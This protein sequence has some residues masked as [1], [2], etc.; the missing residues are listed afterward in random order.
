MRRIL[1]TLYYAVQQV[2]P[3]INLPMFVLVMGILALSF[4]TAVTV[5]ALVSWNIHGIRQDYVRKVMNEIGARNQELI[6]HVNRE[7][8]DLVKKIL[9]F[10]AW[11]AEVHRQDERDSR[12]RTRDLKAFVLQVEIEAVDLE[13]H[14]IESQLLPSSSYLG[15]LKKRRQ[16]LTTQ[17]Q[18]M[19]AG[20]PH[21]GAK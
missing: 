6:D 4:L 10:Q 7:H 15:E 20:Q 3:L 17:L 21:G 8:A 13:I 19:H 14:R 12:A 9:E 11:D 5:L 2:R 16:G 18:Q 1:A